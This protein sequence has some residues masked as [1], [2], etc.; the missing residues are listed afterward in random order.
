MGSLTRPKNRRTKDSTNSKRNR[1]RQ[2][3]V[4]RTERFRHHFL[5]EQKLRF[6]I[7][8]AL[9]TSLHL[10]VPSAMGHRPTSHMMLWEGNGVLWPPRAQRLMVPR[11]GRVD[12]RALDM[13]W[14]TA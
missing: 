6:P 14:G 4:H 1:G 2:R 7:P 8:G 5:R 12:R 3:G 10:T 9:S 11:C 13:A